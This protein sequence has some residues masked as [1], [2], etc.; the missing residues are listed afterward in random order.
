MQN[1]RINDGTTEKIVI[2]PVQRFEH[3]VG[4]RVLWVEQVSEV[5]SLNVRWTRGV[6]A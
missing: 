3:N 5:F 6:G 2:E 4:D 1:F